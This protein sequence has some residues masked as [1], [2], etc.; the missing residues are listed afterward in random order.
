ME[1]PK[2][3][4]LKQQNINPVQ[5]WI[6]SPAFLQVCEVALLQMHYNML[7]VKCA[8]DEATP[9][10]HRLQGA[11]RFMDELLAIAT[12]P[13]PARKPARDNLES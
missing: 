12:P 11:K 2:S 10:F 4:L 5:D 3:R 1:S 9:N 6:A 13:P 7:A 8:P